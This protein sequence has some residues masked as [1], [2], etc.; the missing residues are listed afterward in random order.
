MRFRENR[1]Q[2]APKLR[3]IDV[4]DFRIGSVIGFLSRIHQTAHRERAP[5]APTVAVVVNARNK[6]RVPGKFSQVIL[7]HRDLRP[8][9][10][11]SL[12]KWLRTLRVISR[13]ARPC[14]TLAG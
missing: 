5:F 14:H 9:A 2:P 3:V 6:I 10:L 8:V 4:V 11:V 13:A 12:K 7:T 1:F